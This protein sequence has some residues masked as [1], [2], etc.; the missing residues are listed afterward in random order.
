MSAYTDVRPQPSANATSRTVNS[1]TDMRGASAVVSVAIINLHHGRTAISMRWQFRSPRIGRRGHLRGSRLA[2]GSRFT[3]DVTTLRASSSG[4]CG[5]AGHV[6][7]RGVVGLSRAMCGRAPP[8][9][10]SAR[11]EPPLSSAPTPT[12]PSSLAVTPPRY[13]RD[14]QRPAEAASPPSVVRMHRLRSV[15]SA[16][17]SHTVAPPVNGPILARF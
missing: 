16:Y 1:V 3:A 8:G 14:R 11:D 2:P 7:L 13:D 4:G 12:L 9:G 6:A 17:I 10:G 15:A 5:Q